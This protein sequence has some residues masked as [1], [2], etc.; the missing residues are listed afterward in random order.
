MEKEDNGFR[1]F[2]NIVSW[3]ARTEKHLIYDNKN[4]RE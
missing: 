1:Y 4:S 3:S 2:Q